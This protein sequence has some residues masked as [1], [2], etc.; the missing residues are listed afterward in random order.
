MSASTILTRALDV[1]FPPRC[2]GCGE[3]GQYLCEGCVEF[4][5][6]SDG[7][8]CER[9]WSRC[10]DPLVCAVCSNHLPAYEALRAPF[11]YDGAPRQAVLSLKF[12]G[13]SAIAPTMAIHLYETMRAWSPEVDAIVP[14][15]L[16]PSRRRSRG[17]NQSELLARELSHLADLPLETRALRRARSTRPQTEQPDAASRRHNVADA[18]APGKRPVT[19]SVLLVDDVTTTG[20]TLDACA[21]ALL[22]SGA[23]QVHALTF[24]RED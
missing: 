2:V 13:V 24:T 6:G 23:T 17:Y 19:G 3:F 20:A 22:A 12:R 1:V 5:A 9:C 10:A 7:G 4:S 14:V 11:A 16:H 21:R 8:R 18:F 15:P